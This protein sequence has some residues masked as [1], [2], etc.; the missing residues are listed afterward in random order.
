MQPADAER[1]LCQG[2]AF[3]S[4]HGID[5]LRYWATA[6][7]AEV[8]CLQG[9]W[10]EAADLATPVVQAPPG[11]LLGFELPAYIRIPALVS[12]GRL[13]AR[14]GDPDVWEPLDQAVQLAASAPSTIVHHRA[15]IFA[16]R[17]EAAW[18]T[19]DGRRAAAEAAAIY[20]EVLSL[21]ARW[22]VGELAYWQ[23]KAGTLA[24]LPGCAEPYALQ[25]SGEWRAAAAAWTA[26]G[27]PYEAA[28]ASAEG[29]DD[30]ALRDSLTVL[31]RLGAQPAVLQVGRRMR[32]LGFGRIPRGPRATTRANPA[33]LT[34]REVEVLS[35]M[36]EGRR[37]AEIAVQLFLSPKTVEHHVSA[38]LAK[39]GVAS[40]AEAIGRARDL[41]IASRM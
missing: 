26:L 8:R 12:M 31:E 15:R 38:I 30:G 23:W 41:D 27:C 13:R 35:L 9:R 17:A 24:T 10:P 32:D 34:T 16:A 22:L 29:D 1:L 3:T 6:N 19:G 28:R 25:M 39:L 11:A 37:N 21:G 40:R 7:L 4:E 36:A 18:L 20:D 5:I 2:L 33:N 14:R